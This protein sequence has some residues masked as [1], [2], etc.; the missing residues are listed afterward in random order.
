M[1]DLTLSLYGL[2]VFR[3]ILESPIPAGFLKLVEAINDKN[4]PLIYKSWGEIAYLLMSSDLMDCVEQGFIYPLLLDDNIVSQ[5]VSRGIMPKETIKQAALIDITTLQRLVEFSSEVFLEAVSVIVGKDVNLPMWKINSQDEYIQLTPE[6][7]YDNLLE[8][9]RNFGFGIFSQHSS[10]IFKNGELSPVDNSD[11]IRLYSLIGYEKERQTV[12]DNTVSFL[13]NM[14]ANNCLLYGDVGTGKSSTVKAIANE[15]S[16]E[17]LR[18]IEMQKDELPHFSKLSKILANKPFKFILFFDDLTFFQGEKGY[19]LLKSILEGGLS[20]IPDNVLIY[21]TSNRRHLLSESFADRQGDDI[22]IN[23]SISEALSLSD[24]FG[25]S[26][27]FAKP[28]RAEFNTM[29][30]R[31]AEDKN[32]DCNLETLVEEAQKFAII[33]GGYSPRAAM[34]FIN[35][36]SLQINNQ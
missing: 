33:R 22:H 8:H 30:K 35:S 24:R 4:I 27:N 19:A 13:N 29:I 34:Q 28:S 17:G 25:V 11:T 15:F 20:A 12:I 18:I 6:Q 36:I 1:K 10:F 5:H 9:Y 23:E 16:G 14:P 26:V 7:V 3:N 21:A 2:S 32:L 31:M